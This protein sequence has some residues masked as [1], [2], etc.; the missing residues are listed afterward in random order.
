MT[1]GEFTAINA[2]VKITV[3]LS[4]DGKTVGYLEV[5]YASDKNDNVLALIYLSKYNPLVR[6]VSAIA[7]SNV[8][9]VIDISEC[10]AGIR[11]I[12]GIVWFR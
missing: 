9:V 5:D 4:E 7:S 1:L 10:E 6:T 3:S 2:S 8:F 11:D 12:E